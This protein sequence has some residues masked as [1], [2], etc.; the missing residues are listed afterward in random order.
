MNR[1]EFEVC[2][3]CPRLC[4]HVCPVAVGSAL[5]SAT[6]TQMM[7]V[8]WLALGPG[9][10]AE[11]LA[12]TNLCVDCGACTAH[13]MLHVPVASRLAEFRAALGAPLVSA[14]ALRPISGDGSVV[15]ILCSETEPPPAG[16]HLLTL[17][18]LGH[19]AWRAGDRRV[20][21]RVGAHLA[22]RTAITDR[23]T[24]RRCWRPRAC[25]PSAGRRR[26]PRR[27]S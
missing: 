23:G 15:A 1:A 22:G 13:C 8:A 5:E 24:S 16:T 3:Y 20:P 21:A 7:T 14:E 10:H 4:R 27:G 11:P 18:A 2:A 6:P 25:G 26:P 19:D 17:D 12:G 9:G